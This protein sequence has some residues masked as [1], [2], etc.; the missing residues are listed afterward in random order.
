MDSPDIVSGAIP[1]SHG[2]SRG[3]LVVK[4]IERVGLVGCGTGFSFGITG[5]IVV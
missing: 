4:H 1:W 3:D 5:T 2:V